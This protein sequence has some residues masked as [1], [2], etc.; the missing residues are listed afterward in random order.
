MSFKL[1]EAKTGDSNFISCKEFFNP[2]RS[3]KDVT[4]PIKFDMCEFIL[5]LLIGLKHDRKEI[6]GE[7]EFK[8]DPFAQK[9]IDEYINMK[10]LI[11]GLI[12][13]KIIKSQNI[14]RNEKDKVKDVMKNVLDSNEPTFLKKETLEIMHQ[15]YLGGFSILLEE[16]EYKPPIDVSVFFSKY[17]QLLQN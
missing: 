9:Y 4:S 5:C 14:D 6:I 16:F 17:N 8:R 12:L 13:S 11:T 10:P 2:I 3:K 7:Y 1:V 15:Y